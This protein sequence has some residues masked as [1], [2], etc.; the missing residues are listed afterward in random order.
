VASV[1]IDL[2]LRAVAED[3]G[4][5]PSEAEMDQYLERMAKRAGATLEQVR[6][7]IERRGQ[8]LAVRSE[9]KKSKAFDWLVEHAEVTDEEGNPVDRALLATE[10]RGESLAEVAEPGLAPSFSPETAFAEAE[11]GPSVQAGSLTSQALAEEVAR[12]GGQ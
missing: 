8:R 10:E 7:E 2:A 6:A 11:A 5:E 1:K 12:R 4:I 3:L 9:L